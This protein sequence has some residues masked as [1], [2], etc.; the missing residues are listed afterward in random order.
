MREANEEGSASNGKG[1]HLLKYESN[2]RDLLVQES[3][4]ENE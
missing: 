2:W 4:I 3:E 1:V